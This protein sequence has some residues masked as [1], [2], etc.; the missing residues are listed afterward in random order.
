MI[1]THICEIEN[2]RIAR[3]IRA[4]LSG[5]LENRSHHIEKEKKREIE[6]G[7]GE[8]EREGEREVSHYTLSV[9][10]LRLY[11]CDTLMVYGYRCY[12]YAAKDAC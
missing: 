8:T 1:G 7:E 9:V 3:M 6:R 4:F 11:L 10:I 5:T 12:Y 2:A